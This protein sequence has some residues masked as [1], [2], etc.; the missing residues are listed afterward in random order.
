M[1][2][3]ISK[4][5]KTTRH[6]FKNRNILTPK[7]FRQAGTFGLFVPVQMLLSANKYLVV[8]L[9]YFPAFQQK[10]YETNIFTY[11]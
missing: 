2:Q 8:V 5:T 4:Y 9:I 6:L 11:I 3:N 7:N 10:A 1:L